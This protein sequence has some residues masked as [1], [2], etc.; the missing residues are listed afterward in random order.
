MKIKAGYRFSVTSWEND[1]DNYQTH[2]VDGLSKVKVEVYIRLV[3]L[4]KGGKFSNLLDYNKEEIKELD[5]ELSKF[6]DVCGD[7]NTIK[8]SWLSE[9]GLY[10]NG[11]FYTRVCQSYTV[12]YV[13][14]EIIIEDV[15]E[16]FK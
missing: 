13:P 15:T 1:G 14:T 12:E 5:L 3:N 10:M 11:E 8:E 6:V 16:K 4:F 7:L 2:T 9:V